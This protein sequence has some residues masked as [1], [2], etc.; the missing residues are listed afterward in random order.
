MQQYPRRVRAR[1]RHSSHEDKENLLFMA[2]EI[3][4]QAIQCGRNEEEEEPQARSFHLL[5]CK[6]LVLPRRLRHESAHKDRRMA[7]H[8][9][10]DRRGEAME[11][12]S[13][14]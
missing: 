3:F 9:R 14:K 6:T 13:L 7:E 5:P 4:V 10:S 8:T 12:S 11:D 2:I 1:L